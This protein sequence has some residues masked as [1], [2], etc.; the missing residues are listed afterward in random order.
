MKYIKKNLA[1]IN[2]DGYALK[3]LTSLPE[4][5]CIMG[6]Q[7]EN[8]VLN[9]RRQLH[10]LLR[11]SPEEIVNETPFYQRKTARQAGCQIDYMIQTKFDTLYVCEIKFSR[12]E[13]DRTVIPEVR[14][15][16][17]ALSRPHGMSCRP[18]LIHVNGVGEEVIDTDYF[19]DII[20]M[21]GLLS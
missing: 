9:N 4:W 12:N 6:L 20:D 2:R 8:L 19:A 17:A 5:P 21:G 18:V 14:A 3:S 1:K 16:I 15:K 10:R 7:F 11:L 13:I